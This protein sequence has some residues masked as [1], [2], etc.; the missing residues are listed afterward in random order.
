MY[1]ILP[2]ENVT[3]SDFVLSIEDSYRY[4]HYQP[5]PRTGIP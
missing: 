4:V 1:L 3:I 5:S 2:L